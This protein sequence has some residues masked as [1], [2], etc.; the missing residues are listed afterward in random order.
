VVRTIRFELGLHTPY[1]PGV[2]ADGA[3]VW[4]DL[5]GRILPG[6]LPAPAVRR[7]VLR[8]IEGGREAG[9]IEA[10]R[11]WERLEPGLEPGL[12]TDI[13]A[14]EPID[15]IGTRGV[16]LLT[17]QGARLVWGRAGEE[18]FGVEPERKAANL[19]HAVR[20]QGDLGRVATINVRFAEPF[21]TLRV[22]PPAGPR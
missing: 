6:F 16:V 8:Q 9:V 20:A 3:R 15:E 12:V 17:T 18:R 13:A 7:P 4:I 5:S 1:L 2:R 22:Q 21:Y 14:A 11:T 19:I 10:V